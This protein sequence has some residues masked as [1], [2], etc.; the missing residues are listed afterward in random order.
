ME[1]STQL[2]RRAGMYSLRF[3]EVSS[4]YSRTSPNKL[5]LFSAIIHE[6]VC[7]SLNKNLFYFTLC[8]F[9]AKDDNSMSYGTNR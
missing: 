5:D 8:L 6:N 3:Q 4:E 7:H 1:L 2:K 9:L